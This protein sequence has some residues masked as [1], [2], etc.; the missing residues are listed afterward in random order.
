M[1]IGVYI[2]D[3]LFNYDE[4]IL[5]GFGCFTTR[6]VPAKFK[7]EERIVEA[8]SKIVAFKSEPRQGVTPLIAYIAEKE[9]KTAEEVTHFLKEAVMEMEHSLEAGKNVELEKIGLFNKDIAGNL[10]FEPVRDINYLAEDAGKPLVRTPVQK[11][12]GSIAASGSDKQ[13]S[14]AVHS[15]VNKPQKTGS[16]T[17]EK[18]VSETKKQKTMTE[19]TKKASEEK[20]GL[21]PAL[22]WVAIVL[23]PLLVILIIL[24]ANYNFFF[25]ED[26]FFRPSEVVVVDEPID[27]VDPETV[28]EYVAEELEDEFEEETVIAE[29]VEPAFDPYAKPP[30]PELNRPVF[31]VVVGSFRSE[32]KAEDL[33]LKLRKQDARLADVLDK[34]HAGYHRTHSG[35]YYDLREA[36]QAKAQLPD[37]LREIAWILHR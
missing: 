33:A 27:V 28:E 23:I 13:V 18:A 10:T 4:V 1:K 30:R 22:K 7:P 3:L 35:Y 9:E 15:N 24:F 31:F 37:D 32:S 21:P 2:S 29:P 14:K 25:G 34:T 16:K 17:G 11:P 5:P 26:G 6:Y 20:T 12:A 36:E 19:P 8:P